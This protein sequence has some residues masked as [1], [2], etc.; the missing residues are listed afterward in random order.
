M[1]CFQCV[2]TLVFAPKHAKGMSLRYDAIF[3]RAFGKLISEDWFF[4]EGERFLSFWRCH[5][6]RKRAALGVWGG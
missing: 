3:I 4:A 2:D 6:P 1:V 5:R